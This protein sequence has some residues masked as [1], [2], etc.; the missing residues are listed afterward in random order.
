MYVRD[1]YEFLI[2]DLHWW[3]AGQFRVTISSE[4]SLPASCPVAQGLVV[5]PS[6]KRRIRAAKTRKRMWLVISDS[7]KE[8]ASS[9][10]DL[11]V[12]SFWDCM[13]SDAG[14]Q[15]QRDEPS[16]AKVADDRRANFWAPSVIEDWIRVT[17]R[18]ANQTALNATTLDQAIQE[19]M[20]VI[21]ERWKTDSEQIPVHLRVAIWE[22]LSES[23]IAK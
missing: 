6:K 2:A 22:M 15:L 11:E 14:S 19:R 23:V 18:L 7:N 20:T 9:A 3:L 13:E 1:M 8:L 17:L 4:C 12:V 10:E 5:S 16:T 21:E